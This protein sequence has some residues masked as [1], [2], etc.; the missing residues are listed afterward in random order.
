MG[1]SLIFK[2]EDRSKI[3]SA[4]GNASSKEEATT[5]P[6]A[7]DGEWQKYVLGRLQEKLAPEPIMVACMKTPEKRNLLIEEYHGKVSKDEV[8][9]LLAG[10]TGR[11]LVR[12]STTPGFYTLSYNF[13]GEIKHQKIIHKGDTFKSDLAD[14]EEYKT[15]R[16]LMTYILG[17]CKQ[18]KK[19]EGNRKKPYQKMHEFA[20]HTYA[21][22][23]WC[24]VCG[25]FIW[26]LWSQ[27]LKCEDCGIGIHKRC[28]DTA[29]EI[30]EKVVL[31]QKISSQSPPINKDA[32]KKMSLPDS[33][34]E[35]MLA[36]PKS[37]SKMQN[38]GPCSYEQQCFKYIVS[39]VP[40]S[41]FDRE[42]PANRCYCNE[43]P[44]FGEF[45]SSLHNWC[46]FALVRGSKELPKN[47]KIAYFSVFPRKIKETLD[48]LA[49]GSFY[50]R[51]EADELVVLP[52]LGDII[53]MESHEN[54]SNSIR[55]VLEVGVEN[56]TYNMKSAVD[57][58]Q[59]SGGRGKVLEYWS[60]MKG[61]QVVCISLLIKIGKA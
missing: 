13:D 14:S 36:R 23:K 32:R 20:S 29:S 49:S 50:Q 22:P 55:T 12:D 35:K 21:H 56:G 8:S 10:K 38:M 6:K 61:H 19:M 53:I 25:G 11:Y 30:C 24:D 41:Y 52:S 16:E 5:S 45:N 34:P 59:P 18:M 40:S 43:H 1:K 15:V 58:S 39:Q 17:L 57:D 27:G 26:G 47:I 3:R 42:S 4:G 44:N 31:G 2:M 28:K 9:R 37:V 60:I 33:P 46:K 54:D 51:L 48:A 7:E